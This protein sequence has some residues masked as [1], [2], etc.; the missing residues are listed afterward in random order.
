M[1]APKTKLKMNFV[2]T[3]VC[4][5]QL[6]CYKYVLPTYIYIFFFIIFYFYSY[7]TSIYNRVVMTDLSLF[8]FSSY[9]RHYMYVC[10]YVTLCLLIPTYEFSSLPILSQFAPPHLPPLS[11]F[12]GRPVINLLP[13]KM[14]RVSGEG[15]YCTT[16]HTCPVCIVLFNLPS[17]I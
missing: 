2:L 3:I 5:R 11:P 8:P 12:P 4:H 10:T 13:S 6:V 7:L 16:Y 14:P 1:T 17:S 9:K 15:T